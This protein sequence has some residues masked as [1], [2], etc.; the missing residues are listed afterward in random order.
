VGATVTLAYA[1]WTLVELDGKPV[2]I[3]PD[4]IQPDC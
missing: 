4:E 1:E 3:G 2:E